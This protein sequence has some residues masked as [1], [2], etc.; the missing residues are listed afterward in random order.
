MFPDRAPEEQI[1][2]Y[3]GPYERWSFS[4]ALGKPF[5]FPAIATGA[6]PYY[7]ALLEGAQVPPTEN[8]L[9]TRLPPIWN[10][11]SMVR[12]VTPFAFYDPSVG[13]QDAD[14]S[15]GAPVAQDAAVAKMLDSLRQSTYKTRSVVKP[16]FRLNFPIAPKSWTR[17]YSHD[18]APQNWQAP[19]A[20]PKAIV[21]VID[22]ALPFA[23]RAFL[24]AGGQTR[25]S[26]CWLQSGPG[27]DSACVPFGREIVNAEIDA[28]RATH[29]HDEIALYYHA[30][31]ID[32]SQP[33]LGNI[34]LRHATHGSMVMGLA[35]GNAPLFEA[36]PQGDD[37]QI[38]AVQLPNTIAW[39][40]S[41]FG[42]EMYM[43]SALHYIF[44]RAAR[45]AAHFG[46]GELPLVVNFSYGWSASRHDGK[47]E[48]EIAIE[49]LLHSRRSLQPETYLCM[50]AGNNFDSR[51]HAV[52]EDRD[53]SGDPEQA[54]I[55][56][57]VKPDDLTSS[58]LELWF[59][60]GFDTAGYSVTL[61]PPAHAALDQPVRLEIS[62][63][64]PDPGNGDPRRFVEIEK[65]GVNVGQISADQHRGE[66]WR[67][68]IAL[69]PTAFTRGQSRAAPAGLWTV[70]VHRATGAA[71]VPA[72]A[73]LTIWLQRDDDPSDLN[74]QGRQSRLVSLDDSVD[75]PHT[76]V[77]EQVRGYGSLNGVAS[78]AS[79]TRVAGYVKSTV[80]PC[81]YSGAGGV[82]EAADGALT[83][84]GAQADLC[85]VADQTPSRPGIASIGVLSGAR[86]RLVGTSAACPSAARHIVGNLAAGRA[87]M[88]GFTPISAL[89]DHAPE[90]PAQKTLWAVRLG[91]LAVPGVAKPG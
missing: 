66:R 67:V 72:G 82:L 6:S 69:I 62:A 65:G 85:A 80:Q 29:G 76:R 10:P 33:E 22:D 68:M 77:L 54:A 52:I 55:G 2:T 8:G 70:T 26:H 56:W 40:T 7:T 21:A 59:P 44:D 79:T 17:T 89:E 84:W 75:G 14:P 46:G 16:R 60:D 25:I 35:A 71:D 43:L 64:G 45:I 18:A 31:A 88:E 11:T 19:G 15:A 12:S 13:P 36:A 74:M 27:Q 1:E 9:Q 81:S 49:E 3:T 41:G 20:R 53:F 5:T 83:I 51:M 47:S 28:W 42:K 23:N 34:L 39:D 61:T 37:I 91:D 90:D 63:D 30:G 32:A 87:A 73:P 38:I 24:N 48:M 78:S 86:G 50:P 57:D 58:Y 4:D